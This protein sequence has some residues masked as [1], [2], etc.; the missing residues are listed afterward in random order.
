MSISASSFT[1]P[2]ARQGHE[3]QLHILVV[4]DFEPMR[5][6][7]VNQLRQ[8]GMGENV[9]Q[10]ENGQ[11]AWR[12]LENQKFD[13]ILSDWNMPVLDGLQLLLKIRQDPRFA[14]LPV[15][16]ITAECERERMAQA[17]E[18][19][20]SDV[21][22][23]PYSADRLRERVERALRWKPPRAAAQQQVA[24]APQEVGE[25]ALPA[26]AELP[27]ILVVDDAPDN[28]HLISHLFKGQYKVKLAHN[29][30]RAVS[31]CHGDN[32]PDLVLLDVMMPEMDGF[33]VAARLRE[34]PGS[35]TIPI[36][37]ITALNDQ[38]SRLR[39]MELGAVD[40]ISKPI[41]PV[42]L[43]ARVRNFMRY[44]QLHKRLQDDYDLMLANA[45]LRDEVDQITRHDMKGP[46]AGILGL[47][48]AMPMA[49]PQVRTE[50]LGMIEQV[51]L[52]LLHMVNLSA[53]LYKI[54][55][56]R[57]VLIPQP[58]DLPAIL[59]RMA[60]VSAVT[61]AAKGLELVLQDRGITPGKPSAMGD[62]LLCH[63]LFQ[64]LIKNACE[65][66]PEWSRIDI[67]VVCEEEA[68]ELLVRIANRGA[69]PAAIR[70][71]FW[72][73]FTT[74]GKEGGSGLGTYSARLLAEAQNGRVAMQTDDTQ[75]RTSIE[76]W[77]PRPV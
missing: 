69:V 44:V 13:L 34:H 6:V 21:L 77:L 40:F 4:D 52:Q 41:D 7:T 45:R 64:N 74:Y 67:E 47:L 59:R 3:R 14:H 42:M 65:A 32:P 23:K 26:Q 58:L 22:L 46:L 76:V 33:A 12:L 18:A 27:T 36:I 35:E 72:D 11:V 31:I 2:A 16:M 20:V 51:T 30:A 75:N 1:T 71:R 48:H 28:L 19:G 8:F 70:E 38:D 50:Q 61:Y 29:G 15:V 62:P 68:E 10:A 25:A 39:G 43:Q 49:S 5:K 53:E 9:T 54:E 66:A 55:T 56:G 37:F 60:D 24:A 73:K 17:I 57:F 63:S